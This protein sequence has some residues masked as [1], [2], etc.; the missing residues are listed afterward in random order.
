[1]PPNVLRLLFIPVL[2]AIACLYTR[3]NYVAMLIF[4]V[5]WTVAGIYAIVTRNFT[6][7]RHT[8]LGAK[9]VLCGLFLVL[10]GVLA[11]YMGLVHPSSWMSTVAQVRHGA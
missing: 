5:L 1:M 10:V 4:G 6:T 2:V 9:A 8:Y 7:K 3:Y 11:T